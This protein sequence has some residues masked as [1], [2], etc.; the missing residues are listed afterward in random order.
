MLVEP[1]DCRQSVVAAVVVVA[2]VGSPAIQAIA[3]RGDRTPQ[4]LYQLSHRQY[5]ASTKLL[6]DERLVS[7]IDHGLPRLESICS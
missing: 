6:G 2:G 4:K 1:G 3:N 5:F 7:R